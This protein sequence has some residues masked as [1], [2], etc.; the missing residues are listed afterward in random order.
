MIITHVD[1]GRARV[2]Q[3]VQLLVLEYPYRYAVRCD[4]MWR[5]TTAVH[6]YVG[7]GGEGG[8]LGPLART[9]IDEV[10]GE[11]DI[12][13]SARRAATFRFCG[14]RDHKRAYRWQLIEDLRREQQ[15]TVHFANVV[16][17]GM[18]GHENFSDDSVLL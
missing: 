10:V 14:D 12:T 3:Y 1:T 5:P 6:L 7:E 18:N 16:I 13:N 11:C 15:D 2:L 4:C 8:R 17:L 9:F